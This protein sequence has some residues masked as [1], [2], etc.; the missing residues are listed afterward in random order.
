MNRRKFLSV[1][2]IGASQSV[3]LLNVRAASRAGTPAINPGVQA[4]AWNDYGGGHFGEWITDQFGLP[5]YRYSCDQ[6]TDTKAKS[7]VH[8]QWRSNTDHTHQVGNDRLIAAVSNYGYVQVRQ[9]EGSPKFLNDHCP[10]NG[11][12]G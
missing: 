11:H 7:P 2:G 6:I 3:N 1:M 8:K 5:A 12:Y 4:E 9:D 10:E